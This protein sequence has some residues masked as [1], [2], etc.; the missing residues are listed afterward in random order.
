LMENYNSVSDW[1]YKDNTNDISYADIDKHKYRTAY[2]LNGMLHR[3][4][5]PA[6]IFYFKSGKTYNEQYLINGVQHRIDGPSDI[7]YDEHGFDYLK[8]WQT[9]GMP[10]R[11]D[12]PAI[13]G[14]H[15][16][17][18]PKREYYYLLG[19]KITKEQYHIPGFIDLFMLENS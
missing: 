12:G 13:I 14:Y 3:T 8:Q 10:H 5:G 18:Q 4:N 1:Y 6:V 7:Y 15:N 9:N 2:T 16:N 19:H 17:G 11:T